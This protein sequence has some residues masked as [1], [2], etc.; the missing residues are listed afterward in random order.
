MTSLNIEIVNKEIKKLGIIPEQ[1]SDKKQIINILTLFGKLTE[2][3]SSSIFQK[4]LPNQK[5]CLVIDP[6]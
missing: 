3:L 2:K 6:E 1:Y 4:D 5:N